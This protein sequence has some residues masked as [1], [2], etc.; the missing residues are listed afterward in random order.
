MVHG[1]LKNNWITESCRSSECW[2]ISLN[3]IKK[4]SCSLMSSGKSLNIEKLLN[5]QWRVLIFQDS[6]FHLKV[7]IFL[8]ATNT[9]SHSECLPDTQVWLTRVC[10]SVDFSSPGLYD[11]SPTT[12]P[13]TSPDAP[14]FLLHFKR[15]HFCFRA[16][17][18][19]FPLC[20][21]C[22]SPKGFLP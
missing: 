6:N 7:H 12:H 18:H 2:H 8:L 1:H 22:F 21:D 10:R 19:D 4:K 20:Q 17:A 11:H 5:S 9:I 13:L 15:V 16:F 14:A 3:G